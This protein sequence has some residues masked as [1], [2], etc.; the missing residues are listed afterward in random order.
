M[1]MKKWISALTL[2]FLFL[3]TQIS[4]AGPVTDRIAG[5]INQTTSLIDVWNRNAETADAL[6]AAAQDSID[7][8]QF[9]AIVTLGA[10]STTW[11]AKSV[12]DTT[13]WQTLRSTENSECTAI[14]NDTTN[15]L[16]ISNAKDACME[17]R[18]ALNAAEDSRNAAVQAHAAAITALSNLSSSAVATKA[19]VLVLQTSS[20]NLLNDLDNDFSSTDAI[21]VDIEDAID[22]KNFAAISL[23][24]A[25]SSTVT[26]KLAANKLSLLQ[27][28]GGEE[29]ECT[30]IKIDVSNAGS[31]AAKDS[32]SELLDILNAIQFN[33]SRLDQEQSRILLKLGQLGS[34]KTDADKLAAD[35][36]AADAKAAADKIAADT[37][38]ATD[39]IAAD[40]KAAADKIAADTKAAA[41]KI[42]ADT[43]AA[44][45]KAAADAAA[46]ANRISAEKVAADA[47]IA[48]EAKAAADKIAAEAKAAADKIAAEA[49]ASADKIAADK[50]ASE[51]EAAQLKLIA[52]K[53]AADK[54]VAAAK[55]AAEKEA[56]DKE[57][58]EKLIADAK[59]EA[60]KI[61]ADANAAAA[62]VSATPKASPRA[63]PSPSSKVSVK[64]TP[65][66][67]SSAKYSPKPTVT[68]TPTKPSTKKITIT[69]TKGTLTKKVTAV[70]PICPSGYK[71]K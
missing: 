2:I 32:C 42:A 58:T 14:R 38:A 34:A 5:Y 12:T 65:T 63:T 55:A 48:A 25:R 28:K 23:L 60:A 46:T 3:S 64:A 51:L 36:L 7:S 70:K 19:R 27:F 57:K 8:K 69:C 13:S 24:T 59:A 16:D 49:K 17:F 21:I 15:S 33:Q 53:E 4:I 40:A 71:K 54:V 22:S 26:A 43:K 52:E 41:D 20:M 50:V 45:D 47:R 62:K 37:K 9:S 44:A 56:A 68:P 6:T 61:I 35:K 67:K 10:Q 29:L 11:L 18:D 30:G 66:P 39:K 1:Y 31:K